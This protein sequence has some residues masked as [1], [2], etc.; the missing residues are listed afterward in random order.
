MC[1]ALFDIVSRAFLQVRNTYESPTLPP[2]GFTGISDFFL[3]PSPDSLTEK[4]LGGRSD[5]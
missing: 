1:S 3:E 2:F 5:P 4:G